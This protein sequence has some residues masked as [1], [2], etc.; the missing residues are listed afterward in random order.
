MKIVHV[1]PFYHPVIG[2]VEDVVKHIA[3]HMASK[4]HEVYVVTY[5]RLRVGGVG[6]L[7]REE[8]INVVR[9]IRLRP[10]ITLSHGT[11]NPKIPHLGENRIEDSLNN[12]ISKAS[13]VPTS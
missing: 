1:A 7:P 2:G 13:I 3:E 10:T 12:T 5:N 6:S 8:V 9:V 4:K 11:Y